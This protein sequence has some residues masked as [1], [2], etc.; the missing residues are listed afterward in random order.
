MERKLRRGFMKALVLA[1]IAGV[2]VQNVYSMEM[3]RTASSSF[4]SFRRAPNS[5]QIADVIKLVKEETASGWT[6]KRMAGKI[7]R[8]VDAVSSVEEF[9]NPKLVAALS[10]FEARVTKEV[11]GFF[12]SGKAR[13]DKITKLVGEAGIR[14]LESAVNATRNLVERVKRQEEDLRNDADYQS[15]PREEQ[16]RQSIFL[17]NVSSTASGLLSTVKSFIGF[18]SNEDAP[19]PSVRHS[20]AEKNDVL[21][22]PPPPSAAADKTMR[23]QSTLRP[24]RHEAAEADVVAPLSRRS[25]VRVEKSAAL[26]AL[27]SK[28]PKILAAQYEAFK[29]DLKALNL[30]SETKLSATAVDRYKQQFADRWSSMTKPQKRNYLV[31]LLAQKLGEAVEL[32]DEPAPSA[33]FEPDVA[34]ESPAAVTPSRKPSLGGRTGSVVSAAK[35][36]LVDGATL[37]KVQV[38]DAGTTINLLTVKLS[39]I[40]PAQK[41]F[42]KGELPKARNSYSEE[43]KAKLLER[44]RSDAPKLAAF[45]LTPLGLSLD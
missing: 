11:V 16:R 26:D 9:T 43:E 14:E 28:Y 15:L 24:S 13:V 2:T 36:G 5:A 41:I 39:D 12:G 23:R 32:G 42:L 7:Q 25:S 18:G 20:A 27:L 10:E 35:S 22:P 19:Q 37:T 38:D 1:V 8:V 3:E 6:A 31:G 34:E 45:V 30:T 29:E 21:P 40:T 4:S 33:A 44:V 17:E